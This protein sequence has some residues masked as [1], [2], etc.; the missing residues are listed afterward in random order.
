MPVA[1]SKRGSRGDRPRYTALSRRRDTPRSYL[2]GSPAFLN[3]APA[4]LTADRDA[5]Q[6]VTD[7]LP[8]AAQSTSP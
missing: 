1:A 4:P 6:T 7:A 8:A 2:P 5:T 3:D